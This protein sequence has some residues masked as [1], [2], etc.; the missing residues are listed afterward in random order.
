MEQAPIAAGPLDIPVMPCPLCGQQPR[1][2]DL[3]GWEVLCKCGVNF[4]REGPEKEQLIAAWNTRV[5]AGET[6]TDWHNY[7]SAS[8]LTPN[9]AS[10]GKNLKNET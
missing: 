7:Y 2:V 3:A 6:A 9:P 5:G 10:P 4:C 1:V 8:L